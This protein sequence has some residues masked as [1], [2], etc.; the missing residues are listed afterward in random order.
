MPQ[1]IATWNAKT[2]LWETDQRNLFC[3]L[4]EPYAETWPTSGMTVAGRLYPLPPPVPH[5]AE[6]ESSS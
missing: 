6:N 1:H 5:T 2:Q 3:A 4:Q